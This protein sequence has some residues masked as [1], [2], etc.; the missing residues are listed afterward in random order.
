MAANDETS[1]S[2]PAPTTGGATTSGSG[3]AALP[4][5]ERVQ[6]TATE[7]LLARLAKAPRLDLQRFVIESDV[8][9][10]GM[11]AV[12]K[13]HDQQMNRRLAMQVLLDRGTPQDEEQA[14]AKVI[15]L[16]FSAQL[17]RFDDAPLMALQQKVLLEQMR[18]HLVQIGGEAMLIN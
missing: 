13:I 16:R 5:G 11:G 17:G 8:G 2:Q 12:Y 6:S 14:R 3:G 1:P 4:A 7:V 9:K 15:T 10:G 18:E